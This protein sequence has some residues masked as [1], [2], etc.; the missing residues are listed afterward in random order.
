MGG[1]PTSCIYSVDKDRQEAR[2]SDA[3]EPGLDKKCF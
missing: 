2:G 3:T 1:K